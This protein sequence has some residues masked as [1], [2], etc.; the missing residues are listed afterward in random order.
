MGLE[1]SGGHL[2]DAAGLLSQH[3]RGTSTQAVGVQTAPHQA[4]RGKTA[5]WRPER[6]TGVSQRSDQSR[7][8]EGPAKCRM[9]RMEDGGGAG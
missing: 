2:Q 6:Q 5:E 1:A 8:S 7:M 3:S 9:A 4:S